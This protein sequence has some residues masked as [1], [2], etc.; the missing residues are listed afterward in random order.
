MITISP[1]SLQTFAFFAILSVTP[2]APAQELPQDLIGISAADALA[3]N[4]GRLYR[5]SS[6]VPGSPPLPPAIL[7]A[8]P[9]LGEGSG[10]TTNLF[11]SP[12]FAAIFWDDREMVVQEMAS[13]AAMN[14]AS[15]TSQEDEQG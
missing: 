11:Y 6:Y 14:R 12:S 13:Q 8:D 4:V 2:M 3:L 1:R 7:L 9:T 10:S 5:F 15:H